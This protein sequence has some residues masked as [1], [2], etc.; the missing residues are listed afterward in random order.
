MPLC[1]GTSVAPMTGKG[2]NVLVTGG[3]GYLGSHTVIELLKDDYN[4]IVVDN[5]L[6][7]IRG[8]GY[9]ESINRIQDLTGKKVAF[10]EAN[11]CNKDSLRKVFASHSGGGN[12]I[13]CVIHFAALKAV[14][15]SVAQPLK[16]YGNNVTG[17]AN[18]MEVMMEFG[19]NRLVFS[20]SATV[21]GQ[22][23]YLPV[24]ESHPVGNC[25]NPYGRTK[26][27]M[28]EIMKDVVTAY[29]DFGCQILRYFNPVGAHP[30]GIIG[31]DPNGTPNNLMPY[32]AQV[33]VG[34]REKV[35]IYGN[36]YDTIDGTGCRD[37]I[38]V[39]DLAEG[40]VAALRQILDPSFSGCKIY[41]LGTGKGHTVLEMINAFSQIS[42]QEIPYE[43]T[44]RRPGDVASCY[45]SC[46]LAAR[47]L[48]WH[49]KLS[50]TDMCRDMWTWQSKNP[51]GFAK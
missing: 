26:L 1:M 9:P 46:D 29:P 3:A 13:D 6:N 22:P 11:L 8:N 5:F 15:E 17:S 16:Y 2:K 14:G 42:G 33:A 48:G 36:D 28:E 12:N 30:S 35:M 38:H 27:F 25:T 7:S 10:H 18:L 21:Y 47:E 43:F 41:N 45:A 39:M 4:V 19:V 51:K 44:S 40:H 50:I 32:V 37:Y 49:A 24:D 23:Q 34:R 20:S 31:E